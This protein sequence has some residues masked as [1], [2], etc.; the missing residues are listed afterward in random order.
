MEVFVFDR[1][2]ENNRFIVKLV[3]KSLVYL[4][5]MFSFLLVSTLI[6]NASNARASIFSGVV[7]DS[8]RA[9]F[10]SQTILGILLYVGAIITTVLFVHEVFD[11]FG[12]R[13]ALAYIFGHYHTPKQENR[14]FMFMDI[15]SS[16]TVAEELGHVQYFKWLNSYYKDITENILRYDGDIYQYV[17]DEVVISWDMAHGL[18]HAR[19]LN[20]FFEI[21]KGMIER[22]A[23][24][25]EEFGVVPRFKAGIHLGEVTTG[26]IGMIKKD[27]IY[28]GDVMNT[29][30][31]IQ[32]SCNEYGADLLVSGE[33]VAALEG[34]PNYAF[35]SLGTIQLRGKLHTV[36]LY[37]VEKVSD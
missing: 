20:C 9:F 29:T 12:R 6:A 27:I 31:R 36:D 23:D 4:L 3:V 13:I 5:I 11:Y 35:H 22:E 18:E 28:S 24:Y 33:L 26:E 17:G 16:T 8:L 30:A 25:M 2:F 32:D 7:L 21:K 1:L 19:C 37:S 14:I 15:K 34:T 10:F